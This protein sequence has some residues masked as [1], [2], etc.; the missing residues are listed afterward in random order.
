MRDIIITSSVLILAV[1]LIRTVI[2]GRVS[3]C[4]QY[5][6]WLLVVVRLILPIPLWNSRY[7]VMNFFPEI[8]SYNTRQQES[9]LY[10]DYCVALKGGAS[11]CMV[12]GLDTGIKG[13][14]AALGGG[15]GFE[16][17]GKDGDGHKNKT[18]DDYAMQNGA[19]AEIELA[20]TNYATED[21]PLRLEVIRVF[22][23]IRS[24][25]PYIWLAGIVITGSYLLI[26]QIRWKRYLYANRRPLE[27]V[28]KSK[29]RFFN[30][31]SVYTVEGLPS[32]CLCGRSIYVTAD[33]AKD[34][35]E[36]NHILAHEYCHYR[37]LDS[38]WVVVRCA[39]I[40][41]YWFDPL[42]W[43]AAAVSKTDSELACD[44]AAVKLLGEDERFAYGKTL[45]KL[46]T[47][48]SYNQYI[49]IAATMG[50]KE[51]GIKERISM[52]IKKPKNFAAAAAV[53]AILAVV[54]V[55]ATFS[56]KK[57]ENNS[58]DINVVKETETDDTAKDG[59][60][61]DVAAS[62]TDNLV[63]TDEAD[64][65]KKSEADTTKIGEAETADA[66]KADEADDKEIVGAIV[67]PV[68][69]YG[70]S[71][72]KYI[73]V[74]DKKGG[75]Y[76]TVKE[77]D[78]DTIAYVKQ[79]YEDV[80]N[81]N[82]EELPKIDEAIKS[83]TGELEK[84][85]EEIS[86]IDKEVEKAE[87]E[88]NSLNNKAADKEK[89]MEVVTYLSELKAKQASL[90]E[91]RAEVDQKLKEL[92]NHKAILQA[93]MIVFE[94]QSAED[95][96]LKNNSESAKINNQKEISYVNPCPASSGISAAFTTGEDTANGEN[97]AHYGVDMTAKEGD[98]IVAAADGE[99][100][101][102]GFDADNGNYII[103]F[104]I[105]NGEYTYYTNLGEALVEK[106]DKVSTGEKIASAG[107]SGKSTGVHLHFA[108][109][110]DG[111]YIE[112]AIEVD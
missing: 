67:S 62:D 81:L 6:L 14:A 98:D 107:L 101:E 5:A 39:L 21:T 95:K 59:N 74:T 32:P 104:H 65:A 92:Q 29:D 35:G 28:G 52:I 4:I 72:G 100:V 36:L 78:G 70:D 31:L 17:A 49:G 11:D 46:I 15:F 53:I 63:K 38:L 112:P 83:E 47:G 69:S 19:D 16:N 43:L 25:L 91:I 20:Q 34:A 56:G 85:E 108:V 106:G 86:S 23:I 82:I 30:K 26:Y 50:G 68:E 64:E 10:A 93:Q 58:E 96:L 13:G 44:E 48:S 22:V 77:K 109:S 54:L 102:T 66:P 111:E 24:F 41:V 61:K 45:V 18:L 55:I 60:E 40:V 103:I 88:L 110:R 57:S 2:K 94:K 8:S 90:N 89:S 7:S 51:K 9:G 87:E 12:R 99:V 33:M 37:Q 27:E 97:A 80:I 73:I 75:E 3:P 42:I 71:D 1:L 76:I 79:G 105:L 84:I